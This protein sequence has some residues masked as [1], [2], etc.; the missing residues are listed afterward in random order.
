MPARIQFSE[1]I[2]MEILLHHNKEKYILQGKGLI[3]SILINVFY[4]VVF[5]GFLKYNWTHIMNLPGF[6]S[7]LVRMVQCDNYSN[8]LTFIYVHIC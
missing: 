2:P 3:F 8:A 6:L 1:N 7:I 5:V 4:F